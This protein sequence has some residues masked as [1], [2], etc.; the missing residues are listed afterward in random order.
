MSGQIFISYRREDSSAWAGRL[1][2][3]LHDRFPQNGIF[4]DVDNLPPGVDFVEALKTS[5]GACDVQVVVIGKHWLMVRDEKRRRRLYNPEDFVRLEIATALK[6]A[7]PV[8]PV[9][10]EGAS[11]PRPGDLPD[12]LKPLVRRNA[13]EV[14]HAR[15]RTD[16]ERLIR[17]V[18]QALETARVE[19]QRRHEEEQRLAAEQREREEKE[20][21][22]A[23]RRQKEAQDQL[24]AERQE[25]ERQQA[26]QLETERGQQEEQERLRAE[27]RLTAEQ[28]RKQDELPSPPAR[29]T[30][31]GKRN[32]RPVARMMALVVLAIGVVVA[33]AIYFS[34]QPWGPKRPTV[35]LV[36]ASPSAKPTVPTAVVAAS[37]A[38]TATPL[39]KEPA[40]SVLQKATK[41]QPWK[42]SLG[43][44]F[45]PVAGTEVL[46]SIWDT[47][48][49]D[50]GAFVDSTG[51]DATGGMWWLDKD[52]WT[53]T[54]Q[55]ATWK[56]PGFTQGPTYPVV[57]VS[58]DDA[59]AFCK[60]L[61]DR[62]HASSTL[63][64]SMEYRLPTDEEWSIAVGLVSEPG[65]MPGEKDSK[66]KLYPW[67]TQWPPPPRAGNYAG[68]EWKRTVKGQNLIK[69]GVIH[70]I[71]GYDDGQMWTSP[72]GT[73]E[74]NENGLYDMGGNVWQW[75]QDAHGLTSAGAVV[76]GASWR[77]GSEDS[78]ILLASFNKYIY[79]HGL[80]YADIGFRCVVARESSQ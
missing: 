41:E 3:R 4:M 62:E 47:R 17:A 55:Q 23:K 42:N 75:C 31:P 8:I 35:P 2:D 74:P 68:E 12:D 5:V 44:K 15:F 70:V 38:I 50:F 69:K 22:E 39:A 64:K 36:G 60:W 32:P 33:A 45:V 48:V 65:H 21:L 43:M 7:I 71:A 25:R 9:L 20:R 53:A 40:E 59:K 80:R 61:T 18:E 29:L 19:R 49:E 30:S 78:D 6:R 28:E 26:E 77:H 11:M 52:G 72:V 16:S 14:S 79:D 51:Y 54:G 66:V 67:G 37:P 10:V 63:P 76:R 24:E 56:E 57:G 27:Q 34:S 1:Y 46:F 13:L 73:F 58:W